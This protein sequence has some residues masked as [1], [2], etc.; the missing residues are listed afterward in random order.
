MFDWKAGMDDGIGLLWTIEG[1][2]LW[3][4]T[5]F[6]VV[7]GGASPVEILFLRIQILELNHTTIDTPKAFSPTLQDLSH[8]RLVLHCHALSLTAC[9]ACRSAARW[10]CEEDGLI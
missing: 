7:F 3:F 6:I 1:G 9:R 2:R 8:K 5:L 4:I 10:P